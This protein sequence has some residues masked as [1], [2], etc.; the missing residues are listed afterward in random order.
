MFDQ[1]RRQTEDVVR[2]YGELNRRFASSGVDGI[3]RLLELSQQIERA[4]TA[5]GAQELEWF[6]SEIKQ[7]LDRLV[8]MN[9]QLQRLRD[10]KVALEGAPERREFQRLRG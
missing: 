10:L 9:S 1:M 7:L 6:G 3:P 5:V 8:E 2:Y 4:M